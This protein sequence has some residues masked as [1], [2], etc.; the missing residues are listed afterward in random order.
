[1]VLGTSPTQQLTPGLPLLMHLDLQA[2]EVCGTPLAAGTQTS[3]CAQSRV[4]L[5]DSFTH[6]YTLRTESA[7]TQTLFELEFNK[8]IG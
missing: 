1:M 4:Q 2:S 7:P 6:T 8:T 5:E 3:Y